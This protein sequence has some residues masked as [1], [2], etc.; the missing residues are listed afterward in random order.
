MAE[1]NPNRLPTLDERV[2]LY[3]RAVHGDRDFTDDEER[4][5]AREALLC[6]GSHIK[7]R[8]PVPMGVHSP[9]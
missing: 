8:V 5:N 9:L 4:A 3:L 2:T 7:E 1:K 6:C